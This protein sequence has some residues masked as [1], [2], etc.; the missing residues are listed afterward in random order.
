MKT[1]LVP[2]RHIELE[3]AGD[4]FSRKP[5]EKW[6]VS[7]FTEATRTLC[8]IAAELSYHGGDRDTAGLV[9]TVVTFAV[10]YENGIKVGG[11]ARVRYQSKPDILDYL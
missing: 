1:T 3:F 10:T 7:S 4:E 11:I 8:Q 2:V 9:A 6:K 5:A